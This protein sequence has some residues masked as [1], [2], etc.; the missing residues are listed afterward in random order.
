ML[1]ERS[2]SASDLAKQ[3]KT[4]ESVQ[5]DLKGQ[6]SRL[7]AEHDDKV[8]DL[9]KRLQTALGKAQVLRFLSYDT[10]RH[11][12]SPG[13]ADRV[14]LNSIIIKL[15]LGKCYFDFGRAPSTLL[16]RPII[17]ESRVYF[18]ECKWGKYDTDFQKSQN[19]YGVL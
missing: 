3:Q 12:Y 11:E 10:Y 4:L 9:E 17:L 13:L 7:R 1:D 5:E 6:I 14:S 2:R 8:E 16:Q 19:L 15:L 18:R